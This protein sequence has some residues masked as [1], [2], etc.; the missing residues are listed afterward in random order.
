MDPSTPTTTS[1][2]G[3]RSKS[4]RTNRQRFSKTPKSTNKDNAATPHTI[5]ALRKLA[6]P[7]RRISKFYN[8]KKITPRDGLRALSRAL[9]KERTTLS[10]PARKKSSLRN[11]VSIEAKD[12]G[13]DEVNDMMMGNDY[14]EVEYD[15]DDD[16]EDP[17][18]HRRQTSRLSLAA[19]RVSEAF[20][21]PTLGNSTLLSIGRTS[22]GGDNTIISENSFK[23]AYNEDDKNEDD[24]L[25]VGND[26]QFFLNDNQTLPI[27]EPGVSATTSAT[28]K[29]F[30]ST[31]IS[32]KLQDD[33][34][35][36][37]RIVKS[38]LKSVC[39]ST[40]K[41][42]PN[43]ID[44]IMAIS[45]EFFNQVSGD[46]GDYATHSKRKKIDSSDVIQ[47]MKRQRVLDNKKSV[48]T[49]ARQYLPQEFLNQ[50]TEN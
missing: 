36:P 24:N 27:L 50:L 46:L 40:S 35:I 18:I 8:Y 14:D 38:I 39:P 10:E 48:L 28:V 41:L 20:D 45:D 22:L 1:S 12:N 42:H 5:R 37:R 2:A 13:M 30:K 23:I 7:G 34:L 44:S 32:S 43:T 47:L 16:D 6:T 21:I 49:L 15:N 9:V 11:E 29:P 33:L 31:T 4:V 17:E 3:G 26:N 19:G 25:Y